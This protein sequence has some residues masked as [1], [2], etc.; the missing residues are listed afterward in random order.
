MN[1]TDSIKDFFASPRWGMN[2]L[3]GGVC[4][5]I[6]VI[7]PM[8][9][10]GWLLGGFWGRDGYRAKE[11]P[12]FDFSRF[13][14]YLMRGLWPFLVALVA[15]LVFVPVMWVA[16]FVPVFFIS[17]IGGQGRHGSEAEGLI[18][19]VLVLGMFVV[20]AVLSVLMMLVVKPLMIR[21]ELLQD[22]G[23]SFDFRWSLRFLKLTW[24]E[25]VLAAAFIWVASIVLS[26]VGMAAFCI[27]I[28]FISGPV[29]FAMVHLDRQI[30][31]LFLT[32]GG[33]PLESS[34]KLLDGPPPLSPAPPAI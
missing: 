23:K 27:G 5:L 12:P 28:Y 26:I 3:F 21:A 30:Y 11:F 32:R 16:C 34:P 17:M 29:Y 33:E 14:D 9:L 22:F 20:I 24:L 10:L 2:L 6:P 18:A 8:V 31:Q 13:S 4:S 7:G 1:Y 19:L 25:C 15:S